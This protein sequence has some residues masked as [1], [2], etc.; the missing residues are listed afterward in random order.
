GALEREFPGIAVV[1]RGERVSAVFGR[2]MTTAATAREAMDGALDFYDFL[3]FQMLFASGD[4]RADFCGDGVLNFFD[5]L[6]FQNT[7]AAGCPRGRLHKEA[8]CCASQLSRS[9]RWPSL[10]Q[11]CPLRP[12]R[13][14]RDGFL[15]AA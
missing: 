15:S 7:F 8:C 13:A 1:E 3:E 9:R 2:P 12:S 6:A 14:S 5:F 10:P 4:V 11:R